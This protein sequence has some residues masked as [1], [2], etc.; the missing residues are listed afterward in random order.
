MFVAKYLSGGAAYRA[1]YQVASTVIAGIPL[2]VG[3]AGDA[4]I[5]AQTALNI[6]DLNGYQGGTETG[7]L[8]ENA[9]P[10]NHFTT[11]YGVGGMGKSYIANYI[12]LQAC[13][14]GQTFCG[15]DF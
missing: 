6:T 1:T 4:G 3:A 9:I 2:L 14:G 10:L 15:L 12:G 5:A 8:L 13:M 11:F 7:W